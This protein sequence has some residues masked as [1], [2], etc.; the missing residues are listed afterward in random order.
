[1]IKQQLKFIIPAILWTEVITSVISSWRN[2][3]VFPLQFVIG[4]CGLLVLSVWILAK[5]PWL[6]KVMFV[7]LFFA[8][9]NLYRFTTSTIAFGFSLQFS[10]LPGFELSFDPLSALLLLVWTIAYRWEFKQA[11]LA[12]FGKGAYV[13]CPYQAER[14]NLY[15]TQLE[16]KSIKEL[17]FILAHPADYQQE[18]LNAAQTV[19]NKRTDTKIE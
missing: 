6:T 15:I 4:V 7:F 17:E 9:I 13:S 10:K 19:L 5:A 2:D 3:L 8:S 11:A 16:N 12:L 14:T 1:M 18:F